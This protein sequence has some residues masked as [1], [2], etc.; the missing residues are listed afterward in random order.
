MKIA[1]QT[2]PEHTTYTALDEIWRA[3]DE[4]GFAAAFTFDHFVPLL[5]SASHDQSGEDVM[6]PSG[7]EFQHPDRVQIVLWLGE[8][9]PV[10]R[11]RDV[12]PGG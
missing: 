9:F 11:H 8:N 10:D 7:Q 12:G 5:F 3:A 1:I 6:N 4:L 2:P